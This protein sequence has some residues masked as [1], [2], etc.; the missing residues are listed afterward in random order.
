MGQDVDSIGLQRPGAGSNEAVPWPFL[1]GA[2]LGSLWRPTG[3][4]R[5]PRNWPL[6][7]ARPESRPGTEAE[8]GSL[9]SAVSTR[10]LSSVSAQVSILL[11][12]CHLCPPA[13]VSVLA[14][15]KQNV[16]A[17]LQVPPHPPALSGEVN[18]FTQSPCYTQPRRFDDFPPLEPVELIFIWEPSSILHR[19]GNAGPRHP[20]A[21]P[22][23]QPRPGHRSSREMAPEIPYGST[24]V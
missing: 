10:T 23:G 2:S 12:T 22:L 4:L 9:G 7:G 3:G 15:C 19:L 14:H 16:S 11:L 18:Y 20:P 13:R 1:C 21:P 6:V 24:S 8:Q 17:W 5:W